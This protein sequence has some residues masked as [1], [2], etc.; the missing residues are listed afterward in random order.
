MKGVGGIHY[1][2]LI[3]IIDFGYI[4]LNGRHREASCLRMTETR[5]MAEDQAQGRWKPKEESKL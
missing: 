1:D 4:F 2:L 3:G 5:E